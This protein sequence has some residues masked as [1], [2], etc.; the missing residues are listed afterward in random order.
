MLL[1][2]A[3]RPAR[4]DWLQAAIVAAGLFALYAA[5]SPRSVALEDD[6]LF[7]LSSYFLGIEHPPGYPLFTLLGK[8]FTLLPVGSVAYRV[9]LLSALLGALSCAALWLCARQLIEGRLPAYVAALGLGLSRT[10]WS[11]AIIAEVYTFNTLFLFILLYM[12]LRAAPPSGEGSGRIALPA[13]ALVF[14]LSLSN[15]WPLML[16]VAPGFAALLWP[17]RKEVLR[18]SALLAPLFLLGLVPYA[19]L[20]VR[21]RVPLPISFYGPL[22]SWGEAW[23]MLSRAGYASADVSSTSTGLDRA[24]FFAFRLCRYQDAQAPLPDFSSLPDCG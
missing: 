16:L 8:L 9:H 13:I 20:V 14:G 18:R 17:R 11:Q 19:W 21:S 22:E 23:F 15:H 1:A 5:T 12:G 4:A 24:R 3:Y 6:G 2:V 7:V 10:F